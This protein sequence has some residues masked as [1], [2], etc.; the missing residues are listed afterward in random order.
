MPPTVQQTNEPE[1]DKRP[2]RAGERRLVL[3]SAY[4]LKM[5]L[6]FYYCIALANPQIRVGDPSKVLQHITRHT[7]RF[8]VH[9]VSISIDALHPI[10]PYVF[11]E[12]L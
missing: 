5:L 10:Q 3:F 2:Q 8:E 1:R 4:F 12:K 7:L 11:G 6:S 9:Y